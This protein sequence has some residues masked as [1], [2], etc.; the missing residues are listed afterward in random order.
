MVV[1]EHKT[2]SLK[3]TLIDIA[4]V[5]VL[6]VAVWGMVW[7]TWL[8]PVDFTDKSSVTIKHSYNNLVLKPVIPILT[9]Y[10]CVQVTGNTQSATT[11]T[12]PRVRGIR[13]RV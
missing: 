1:Q 4:E 5:I 10:Q 11:R 3:T 2:R 12:G 6:F 8:R 9:S 7:V 13:F